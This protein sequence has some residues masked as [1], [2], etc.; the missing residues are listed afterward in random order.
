MGT[1]LMEHK[2]QFLVEWFLFMVSLPRSPPLT[3]R[4]KR[5]WWEAERRN[6]TAASNQ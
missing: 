4:S 2:F 1:K 3:H 5:M 6:V